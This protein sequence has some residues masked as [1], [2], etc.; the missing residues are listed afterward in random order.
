MREISRFTVP[1][2][3]AEAIETARLKVKLD[4]GRQLSRNDWLR[5]AVLS[6]LKAQGFKVK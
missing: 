1:D 4:S 6:A 2:E 3:V 5:A